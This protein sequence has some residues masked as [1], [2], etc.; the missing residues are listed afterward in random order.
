M[1]LAKDLIEFQELGR[2]PAELD[3]D[4]PDDGSG[5]EATVM[6]N[7]AQWHKLKHNQSMLRQS[8]KSAEKP[9]QTNASKVHTLSARSHVKTTECASPATSQLA[10]KCSMRHQ[11]NS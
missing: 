4:R 3:Q 7:R 10:P 1:S 2:I 11:Q 6:T 5:I 9:Q 8:W